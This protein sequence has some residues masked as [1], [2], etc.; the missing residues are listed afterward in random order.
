MSRWLRRIRI[1]R[2]ICSIVRA[3]LV[4]DTE[5]KI[6]IKAESRKYRI[7]AEARLDMG[8]ED[9]NTSG[10]LHAGKF[11]TPD[12]ELFAEVGLITNSM[13]MAIQPWLGATALDLIQSLALAST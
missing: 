13:K 8:R 9:D 12:D 2:V 11:V 4:P 10:L 1:R 7:S 6:K 3:E 5:T